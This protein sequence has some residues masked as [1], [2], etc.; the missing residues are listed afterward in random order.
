MTKLCDLGLARRHH[1]GAGQLPS[2]ENLLFGNRHIINTQEKE[3]MAQCIASFIPDNGSL[4]L[5]IGT[6]MK[7]IAKQLRP[8][9]CAQ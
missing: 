3:L 7:A 2:A 4:A 9:M 1:G 5:G 6:I 8:K